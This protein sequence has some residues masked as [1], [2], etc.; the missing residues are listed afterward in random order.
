MRA[1]P[2]AAG[3][4]AALSVLT[5]ASPLAAEPTT[6]T[7]TLPETTTRVTLA[8]PQAWPV[9]SDPLNGLARAHAEVT[10]IST[11]IWN[12]E[13]EANRARAAAWY[14]RAFRVEQ[15]RVE[16]ARARMAARAA[17]I[18]ARVSTNSSHATTRHRTSGSLHVD[19]PYAIPTAIVMCESGGNAKA[20]NPSSTASGLYQIL[21]STWNGYGGYSHAADAPVELQHQKAS[22]I[23]AGGAGRGAWVC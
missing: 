15:E 9:S 1:S 20:E 13:V 19:G 21:D 12:R 4:L 3:S 6:S 23:W 18:R 17:S 7:P 2:L 8:P 22:Q 10:W 11:A 14:E 16:A 5:L